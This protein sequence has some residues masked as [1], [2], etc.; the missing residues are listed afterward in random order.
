M[1]AAREELAEVIRRQLVRTWKYG[2]EPGN[3]RP[4]AAEVILAAADE[5]A[6]GEVAAAL[7]KA[8]SPEPAEGGEAA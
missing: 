8:L 2:P 4:A 6:A 1:S 7:E 3:G 5:Y